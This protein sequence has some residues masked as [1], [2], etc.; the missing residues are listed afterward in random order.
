MSGMCEL[1]VADE[2]FM[3]E[4]SED[5]N[6]PSEMMRALLRDH[7]LIA[8]ADVSDLKRERYETTRIKRSRG[9]MPPHYKCSNLIC[10]EIDDI[11]DDIRSKRI[12]KARPKPRMKTTSA[13]LLA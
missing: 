9:E 6:T 13:D 7:G 12:V 3:S 11:I 8:E 2:A 5:Q 1:R 4:L 10:Y